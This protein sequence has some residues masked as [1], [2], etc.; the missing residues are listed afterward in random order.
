MS[1]EDLTRYWALL[2]AS[3]IGLAIALFVVYRVLQD[4]RRGRL[5]SE[6]QQLEERRKARRDAQRTLDK[7]R[8]R[9]ER[10]QARADSAAP[11]RVDEARSACRE[12]EEDLRLIDDQLLIVG[13]RVRTIIL[14]DYPPKRQAAMRRRFLGGD[15]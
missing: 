1:I 14:E 11:R 6:L 4:S 9:L 7:A 5:A 10:L 15:E 13:N 2:A 3:V 12:A 8:T